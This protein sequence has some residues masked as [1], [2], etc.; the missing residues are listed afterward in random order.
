MIRPVVQ[1]LVI[2]L[3]VVVL[4]EGRQR[5]AEMGLP[6]EHATIQTFLFDGSDESFR[7]R[8][9]VRRA[10][11]RLDHAHPGGRQRLPKGQAPLRIPV[12]DQHARS[13]KPSIVRARE[14][15]RRLHHEGVIGMRCWPD[16]LH[17]A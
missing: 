9:T 14:G 7:V 3:P 10:V 4:R 15:A 12:A 11:R 16:E 8:V 13:T 5:A 6:K 2:S 17:T 1:A